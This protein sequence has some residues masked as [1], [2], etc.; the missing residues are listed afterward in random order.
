MV[1]LFEGERRLEGLLLLAWDASVEAGADDFDRAV[2]T[3]AA[4]GR[5]TAPA[6][7]SKQHRA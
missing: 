6:L 3:A 5:L 7:L 1:P 4:L 2:A